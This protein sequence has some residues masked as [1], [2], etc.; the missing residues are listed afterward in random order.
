MT[1]MSAYLVQMLLPLQTADGQHIPDEAMVAVRRTLTEKFG[2]VTAYSRSPA[3]GAWKNPAGDVE[4]DD[5]IMVEVVVSDLDRRWWATY[6]HQLE[7]A[8][9][10][11]EIH[12]RAAA[13]EEL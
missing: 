6:R 9:G 1:P 4:R 13:V 11:N 2:G 7:R 8:L 12:V 5:V 10:Q 3:R